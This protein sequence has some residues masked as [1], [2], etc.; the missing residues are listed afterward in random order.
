MPEVGRKSA[1]ENLEDIKAILMDA[2]MV[3]V[4]AGM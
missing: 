2:D 4:T 1:E 3:F